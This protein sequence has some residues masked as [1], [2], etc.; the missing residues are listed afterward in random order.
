M[1]QTQKHRETGKRKEKKKTKNGDWNT[2]VDG[3]FIGVVLAS[4]VA[5]LHLFY[6][7]SCKYW[8]G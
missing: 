4:L 7:R 8:D 2:N 3:D 6:A 1:G 5:S